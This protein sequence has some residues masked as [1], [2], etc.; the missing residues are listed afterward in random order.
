LLGQNEVNWGGGTNS[1]GV[2]PAQKVMA[3]SREYKRGKYHCTFD[4]LFDWF[5]I[6]CMNTD[7]TV[8]VF[9]C[10]TG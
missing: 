8:F 5:G 10:K 4:L 6:S 7:M 1:V 3:S 2:T 9:I